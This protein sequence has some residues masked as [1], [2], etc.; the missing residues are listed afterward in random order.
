MFDRLREDLKTQEK[1]RSQYFGTVENQAP[2][3]DSVVVV[4]MG[5]ED[6]SEILDYRVLPAPGEFEIWLHQRNGWF[7]AFADA[8]R[9]LI[10]QPSESDGWSNLG[11][12]IHPGNSA[13]KT[14][15]I[16]I[17]APGSGQL[18]PPRKLVG[19]SPDGVAQLQSFRIGELT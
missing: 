10:F 5:T 12:P 2:S 13:V 7:F 3:D 15:D 6:G 11:Q 9:D 19:R 14:I 8:N 1:E 17:D 18:S 4:Y 16:K